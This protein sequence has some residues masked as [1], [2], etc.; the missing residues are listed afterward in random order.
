M[1]FS[2]LSTVFY[3]ALTG[4][5]VYNCLRNRAHALFYVM[6]P[7]QG[8]RLVAFCVMSPRWGYYSVKLSSPPL[9]PPVPPVPGSS[10]VTVAV[11]SDGLPSY[12]TRVIRSGMRS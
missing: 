10:G 8:Y 5:L 12:F 4:L 6:S 9:V 3:V 7:L 2:F 11:S 1:A